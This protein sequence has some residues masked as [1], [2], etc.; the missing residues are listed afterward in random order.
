VDDTLAILGC[1]KLG[2]ILAAGLIASA[3]RRPDQI[4]VTARRSERAEE[5]AA[6]Y[7]LHATTSN[8]EAARE[9]RVLVISTKPQDVGDLLEQIADEVRP[10]HLILSV[11]AAIS[12][13]FIE[14]R[15]A[16]GV[17]VVRAMPNA[18]SQVGEGI[19]GISAGAHAGPE[20]LKVAEDVLGHVGKVVTV[21]EAYMDAVTA[22]SGSG[23]HTTS[24]NFAYQLGTVCSTERW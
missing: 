6:R 14:K 12:T 5:L 9:A 15:L 2:E 24:G 8:V 4:I 16:A 17:P 10:H 21:G 3:W 19:A 7:G 22:V 20:H 11:A 1:G 13:S 23:P 18:P